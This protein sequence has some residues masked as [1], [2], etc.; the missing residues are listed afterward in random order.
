MWS[1]EVNEGLAALHRIA[2]A[3]DALVLHTGLQ[4]QALDELVG[5]LRAA[6]RPKAKRRRRKSAG[7]KKRVS[8]SSLTRAVLEQHP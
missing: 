7:R 2:S 1:K 4:T 5:K 3:L 8:R 6:P